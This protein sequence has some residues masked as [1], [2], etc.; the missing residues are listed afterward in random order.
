MRQRQVQDVRRG[1]IILARFDASVGRC[2]ATRPSGRWFLPVRCCDESP[3]CSRAFSARACVCNNVGVL[4]IAALNVSGYAIALVAHRSK[5]ATADQF[6]RAD[7]PVFTCIVYVSPAVDGGVRARMA[8]LYCLECTAANERAALANLIPAFKQ[9]VG[10]LLQNGHPIR[11]SNRPLQPNPASSND[12]FRSIYRDVNVVAI[13]S[14]TWFSE[15]A[16]NRHDMWHMISSRRTAV[17]LRRTATL[18]TVA[19]PARLPPTLDRTLTTSSATRPPVHRETAAARF[20]THGC[21]G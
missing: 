18:T 13:F 19:E 6:K 7:V 8:H 20:P 2:G 14:T 4:Q 17:C 3:G 9:R 16:F 5:W 21:I 15:P 10:E 1:P 11:G 12:S